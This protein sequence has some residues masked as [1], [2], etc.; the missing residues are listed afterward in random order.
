M[1]SRTATVGWT[2]ASL[3]GAATTVLLLELALYGLPR[4]LTVVLTAVLLGA[5]LGW[6]LAAPRREETGTGPVCVE[7]GTRDWASS[8]FGFCIHCGSRRVW[9]SVA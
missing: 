9:A 4:M 7:C 2:L 6:P 5:A 3:A 8:E 1:P